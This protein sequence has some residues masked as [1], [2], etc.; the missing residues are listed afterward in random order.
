MIRLLSLHRRAFISSFVKVVL[1]PVEHLLNIIAIGIIIGI[2]S[3]VYII[4]KNI[5]NIENTNIAYPQIMVSMQ[6]DAKATDTSYIEEVINK[7]SGKSVRGYKFISKEEGLKE[8]QNDADL[9]KIASDTISDMGQVVPDVLIINTN[10]ADVKTL[11]NLKNKISNLP[12][13]E[14]V[15]LDDHYA[16]KISDLLDFAKTVV[17]FSE[18]LFTIVL[19]LVIYNIIRLQ[20]LLRQDEISV[21]RLIGASDAFIMRPLIYYAL[22]QV[23]LGAILSFY[24]VNIL[25]NFLNGMFLN[26]NNLFGRGFL[27]H[28]L[29]LP[30]MIN[31]FIILA[32]FSAFAVF[33]AVKMV[34]RNKY[35]Q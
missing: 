31:I 34:F 35:I 33:I 26:L 14:S 21:S 11:T 6:Q 9:K 10:T 12:K 23:L 16:S 29:N 5:N 15:D 4:G 25:V 24:L 7:Y 8:L 18:I 17:E 3:S 13:V 20:M 19:I 22:M 30:Q 2:L 27:F 28:S 32:V 1:S